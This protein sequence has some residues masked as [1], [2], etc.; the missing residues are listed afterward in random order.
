M[1]TVLKI[2][3]STLPFVLALCVIH[4]TA[5]DNGKVLL[6][7]LGW[8]SWCSFGPC[9]TDICNISQVMDT[10]DAIE[11]N[12][13]KDAGYN[14][15]TLDDCFAMRRNSTTLAMYPDPVRFPQGFSPAVEKAHAAG[16]NFGI[17]TSAGNYT[18]H[19]RK[20]NCSGECNVGSL[21]YYKQDAMT[22]AGWGLDFVK[23]DWCSPSVAHLSCETQYGEMAQS[24]NAT[25]REVAFY[26]SCGGG[27]RAQTWSTKVANIWRIGND[28]LDC[29]ED[30]PCPL[31]VNYTSR[32][33]GTKE[34]IQYLK[35]ISKYAGPGGYN[36]PDFLKT[37]GESCTTD[38]VPGDLCPKQT[39][40]EYHTEFTMWAMASAP[41]LVST[42]VRKLTDIQRSIILNTE[43]LAVDQQPIAGDYVS[44]LK[45]TPELST[46]IDNSSWIV[47]QNYDPLPDRPV[48]THNVFHEYGITPNASVCQQTCEANSSCTIFEWSGKSSNCWWR[49][50]GKWE[51][52]YAQLRVGGCLVGKVK[53]CSK[54]PPTP[55]PPPPPPSSSCE[56]WVCQ[57]TLSINP[58]SIDVNTG[59]AVARDVILW[60]Y[61]VVLSAGSSCYRALQPR[62]C[63]CNYICGL[64]PVC[65]QK[66]NGERCLEE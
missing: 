17:Y 36:T 66:C 43:V 44:S 40:V 14:Y 55:P 46:N 6:P 50:D 48:E 39:S 3:I 42:D 56:L 58:S 49:L 15:V 30:G 61:R 62:R 59:K 52:R 21:G 41:M 47:L 63:E 20:A 24:L 4:T 19:A 13:M 7:V 16:F 32:G 60:Y 9:G 31:A 53:G 34:A 37:G 57:C 1:T 33:H 54:V 35:G 27:G 25:G 11:S 64:V 28:H 29:W 38:A 45:C 10:I 18:C 23:M 22:F 51:L 12:G 26:M 65:K 2:V 5:L 8:N